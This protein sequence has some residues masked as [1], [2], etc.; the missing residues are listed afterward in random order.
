MR[1]TRV[2]SLAIATS[3]LTVMH[4]AVFAPASSAQS[5]PYSFC[6][7][8]TAT[9]TQE[10]VDSIAFVLNDNYE[11]NVESVAPVCYGPHPSNGAGAWVYTVEFQ[12]GTSL[13]V[14]I[15]E[16]NNGRLISVQDPSKQSAN[17]GGWTAWIQLKSPN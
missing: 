13:D 3:L 8:D 10:L 15:A 9:P 16:S 14:A 4:T 12:N 2:T 17:A 7:E 1:K 11:G 6:T 5:Y